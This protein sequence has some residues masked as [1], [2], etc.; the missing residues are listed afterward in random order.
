MHATALE[1]P[2]QSQSITDTWVS[3]S[4]DTAF[5]LNE[6]KMVGG[7]KTLCP[8]MNR[9]MSMASSLQMQWLF[10]THRACWWYWE[11]VEPHALVQMQVSYS[12]ISNP[13]NALVKL[14]L[15]VCVC[16]CVCVGGRLGKIQSVCVWVQIVHSVSCSALLL[17]LARF[18]RL[19]IRI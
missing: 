13:D 5:C 19:L 17:S 12:H 3:C 7:E 11:P 15:C 9:E 10:Q 6:V 14:G 18:Y 8:N 2:R 4:E 16:V 1:L